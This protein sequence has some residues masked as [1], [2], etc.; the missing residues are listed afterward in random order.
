[1]LTPEPMQFATLFVLR[2]DT[3]AAALALA[4]SGAFAPTTSELSADQLP[5]LPA[6]P[7]S[8]RYQRARARLEKLLA[9]CPFDL[10]PVE[11]SP[12]RV[13]NEHELAQ[14]DDWL[15]TAWLACSRHL[16]AAHQYEQQAQHVQ[17]LLRSLATFAQFGVDL[18]LLQRGGR[19]LDTRVGTIASEDV[20]RLQAALALVHY[21]L[22]AYSSESGRSHCLIAGPRGR[23]EELL[24]L[25]RSA[26]WHAIEVPPEFVG[27]PEDVHAHLTGQLQQV[28]ARQSEAL[29][30]LRQL[31]ES[32]RDKLLE[33]V[34]VLY[35]AGPH[36]QMAGVLRAHG[37]LGAVS[38]WVPRRALD[39]LRSRLAA[40][41]ENRYL[42]TLR[43]PGPEEAGN[44]PSLTRHMRWLRPFVQLVHNYG[45]PRYGEIDPTLLF[46]LSY[47][48]MFGV[49]FGDVGHGAVIA[50]AGAFIRRL[51][52]A[53]PF[54]IAAGCSSMLFGGLYGS[55]FGFEEMFQPL[56]IA[57]LTDPTRML[58]AAL[59]WGIGFI[60]LSTLLTIINR[61]GERQFR[62]ALLAPKGAAG[63]LFY[64][65]MLHAA[66][67]LFHAEA[68][69]AFA[70][71]LLLVPLSA[72]AHHLWREQRGPLS[73]R[74]LVVAVET[75]ETALNYVANTLSFLRVAAFSLNHVALAIAVF[76]L[77]H[78]MGTFG[79]WVTVILGNL[80][81][82]VLEGAIVAIQVLRLEYYEGF[83]RFYQG[84][85]KPYRPL[86]LGPFGTPS[87]RSPLS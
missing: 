86:A 47:I 63:L 11:P 66:Y 62:E 77:A 7:F 65:G 22:E 32:Y 80:F 58:L 60:A 51:R 45:V 48:L 28:T 14:V 40:A 79:H 44:V 43:D 85:G 68:L 30:A 78:M 4:Q 69:G 20:P 76:A 26:G 87:P 49:M 82:L 1:M 6:E 33:A 8:Q 2:E 25:L 73:E 46:A 36:A 54:L 37:G 9:S 55:V 50:A 17:A 61:L 72:V 24:P 27:R 42:L 19:F 31:Q 75:F 3:A 59:Y 38:G 13:I 23:E 39:G 5:E 34:Q 53:R 71:F 18:G 15:G 74:L 56:W 41:L 57:P 70:I 21:V 29:K 64:A 10:L 12:V 52:F 81:I 35:S 83:S 67:N 84:T 16:D